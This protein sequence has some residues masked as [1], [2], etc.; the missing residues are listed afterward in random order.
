MNES[1]FIQLI[2]IAPFNLIKRFFGIIEH[3][4]ELREIAKFLL[5][6]AITCLLPHVNN[7]P[8]QQES[9]YSGH[10]PYKGL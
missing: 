10:S 7:S 9:P 6:L 4:R 3:R 1:I 2:H 8:N 5:V